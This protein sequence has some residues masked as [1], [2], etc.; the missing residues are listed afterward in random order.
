MLVKRIKKFIEDLRK[1]KND[2][3]YE[4][5]NNLASEFAHKEDNAT[6]DEN[7]VRFLQ[8]QFKNYCNYIQ[9]RKVDY[10][11]DS[12]GVNGLWITLA[13]ELA[14][15][16]G[17][18]YIDILF[19][20]VVN[21]FDCNKP[22]IKLNDIVDT[23]EFY[24]GTDNRILYTLEGLRHHLISNNYCLSTQRMN[25][26]RLYV[27]KV[28]EL[29]GINASKTSTD[30]GFSIEN[31]YFP[32]TWNFL[33][34][35]V[36]PGLNR[37]NEIS[38]D[39]F[40]RFFLLI[41]RYFELKKASNFTLFQNELKAFFILLYKNEFKEINQF[42][43]LHY[44]YN[45]TT[46]YLLD[47]LI[48]LNNAQNFNIDDEL[49]ILVEWFYKINPVLSIDPGISQ[50]GRSIPLTPLFAT[51]EYQCK[52]ML[53][54]LFTLKF[55][56]STTI[57]LYDRTHTVFA[58]AAEIY[59]SFDSVINSDKTEDMVALYKNL[60]ESKIQKYKPKEGFLNFWANLVGDGVSFWYEHVKKGTLSSQGLRWYDPKLLMHALIRFRSYDATMKVLINNFL[61]GLI[62]TYCLN[63]PKFQRHMRINILFNEFLEIIKGKIDASVLRLSLELWP[64]QD[65]RN[66]FLSSCMNYLESRLNEMK[67]NGDS[68]FWDSARSAIDNKL[69][70]KEVPIK[71]MTEII[72]EYIEFLKA[73]KA[74]FD[75]ELYNKQ[76]TY[77][78]GIKG[79][80]LTHQERSQVEDRTRVRADP[81]GAPT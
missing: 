56:G 59:N 33:V 18:S 61:D 57:S 42:Y 74:K 10:T 65:Y 5:W 35:K 48:I 71:S 26:N 66:N 19:L 81:V 51:D 43:G 70:T 38:P 23:E 50:S 62:Q 6:L 46:Y 30:K 49:A 28:V 15:Y 31:E 37:S 76:Y 77:L 17:Q 11:R 44:E 69:K 75:T 4:L 47:F 36:F 39:L 54:S 34:K 9:N 73:S 16:T 2:K 80:I 40:S 22:E 24:L 1:I 63:I 3:I 67:S 25:S 8:L 7:E 41:K 52:L 13:K 27:L 45:K 20:N 60:L 29:C 53:L 72:G 14:E 55:K 12:K 21:E 58:E 64:S 32:N 68:P 79:P 78:L